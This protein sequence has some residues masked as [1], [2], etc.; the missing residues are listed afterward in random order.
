MDKDKNQEIKESGIEERIPA[1][2]LRKGRTTFFISLY[3]NMKSKDT[4]NDKLKKLI[5]TE[6][7]NGNF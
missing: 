6:I 2:I 3:F 7:E 1:L 5:K 4:L